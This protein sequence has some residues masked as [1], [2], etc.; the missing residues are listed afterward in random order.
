MILLL[1]QFYNVKSRVG[2]SI[3]NYTVQLKYIIGG[4]RL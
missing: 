4:D 2:K 1:G 3:N